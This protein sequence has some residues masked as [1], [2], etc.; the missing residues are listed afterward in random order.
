M[1]LFTKKSLVPDKCALDDECSIDETFV[2]LIP[3]IFCEGRCQRWLHMHCIG[4]KVIPKGQF[5]CEQ[6]SKSRQLVKRKTVTTGTSNKKAKQKAP[7]KKQTKNKKKMKYSLLIS[8][9]QIES[10]IILL[11]VKI[12][13][14]KSLHL[15]TSSKMPRICYLNS[16][17][18]FLIFHVCLSVDQKFSFCPVC[19]KRMH[20]L[21][22]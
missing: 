22:E 3:W 14:L 20:T 7:V 17:S 13:I 19:D 8:L 10:S 6:C 21:A 9:H 1:F 11:L 5:Y 16:I 18:V 2:S 15:E 4:L 12:H